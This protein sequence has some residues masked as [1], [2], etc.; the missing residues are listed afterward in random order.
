MSSV[1]SCPAT[2]MVATPEML[3]LKVPPRV[4]VGWLVD[5]SDVTVTTGPVLSNF[6]AKVFVAVVPSTFSALS[7]MVYSPSG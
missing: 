3:S 6:I 5:D 1:A 2:V 7:A 4:I